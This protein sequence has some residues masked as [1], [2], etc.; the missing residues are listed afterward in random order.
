[1]SVVLI[2]RKQF[3]GTSWTAKIGEPAIAF[4]VTLCTSIRRSAAPA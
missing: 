2:E 1:M 3:V 4:R